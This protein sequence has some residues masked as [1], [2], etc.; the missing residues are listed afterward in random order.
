MSTFNFETIR[1]SDA[2]IDF[3]NE[4][5]D[6][7]MF[8]NERDA[9]KAGVTFVDGVMPTMFYCRVLTISERREVAAL[10]VNGESSYA[11]RE[12][13]FSYGVLRVSNL[14]HKDG[15]AGEWTRPN[16]G[17]TR[18]RPLTDAAL[19]TFGGTTID[20]IGGVI[21]LRSF[22][23]PGTPL[24]CPLLATSQRAALAQSLRLAA[25]KKASVKE[26][27]LL[28]I[29]SEVEEALKTPDDLK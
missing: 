12:R 4:K 1:V 17:G 13:A 28:A 5:I 2:A 27:E 16:D 25:Q 3:E 8:Y 22:L 7:E 24:V 20:E 10:R 19:D 9:R 23:D 11:S 15:H 26:A 6:W 29:K 14:T 21:E 18:A